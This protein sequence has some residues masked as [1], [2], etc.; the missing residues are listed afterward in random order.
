MLVWHNWLFCHIYVCR[1]IDDHSRH[2]SP[3]I[4]G[5]KPYRR[6]YLKPEPDAI[7]PSQKLHYLNRTVLSPG[8]L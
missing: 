8:Y 2:G 7:L 4:A 6:T 3:G 5:H 1:G